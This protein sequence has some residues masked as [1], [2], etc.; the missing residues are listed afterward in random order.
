MKINQQTGID[1]ENPIIPGCNVADLVF[2]RTK[3]NFRKAKLI[4]KF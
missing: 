3:C 4:L 2:I 1:V